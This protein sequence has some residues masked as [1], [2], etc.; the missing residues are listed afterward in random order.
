[1]TLV[2]DLR[3]S[4]HMITVIGTKSVM[5]CDIGQVSQGKGEAHLSFHRETLHNMTNALAPRLHKGVILIDDTL[6]TDGRPNREDLAIVL[7]PALDHAN[8][9][10]TSLD[11][12]SALPIVVTAPTSN[13]EYAPADKVF[14]PS[15]NYLHIESPEPPLDSK[16]ETVI[17]LYCGRPHTPEGATKPEEFDQACRF[18][19]LLAR[20]IAPSGNPV[21]ELLTLGCRIKFRGAATALPVHECEIRGIIFTAI[22]YEKIG[23]GHRLPIFRPAEAQKIVKWIF[24]HRKQLEDWTNAR[25]EK[26]FP[27]SLQKLRVGAEVV[28]RAQD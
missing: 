2:E 27:L 19:S 26:G 14:Q 8:I 4:K 10:A 24:M 18:R 23:M 17:T 13:P 11:A 20:Y 25:M 12:T 5:N 21:C 7:T 9:A 6:W 22:A 16:R 3:L 1:M 15:C 28:S